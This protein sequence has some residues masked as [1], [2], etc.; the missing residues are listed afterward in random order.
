[1]RLSYFNL[2][3]ELIN[4]NSI[5]YNGLITKEDI[6]KH[7]TQED[8]FSYY[9]KDDASNLGVFHSP[10]RDDNIPS[11][12]LYFHR[13]ERNVIMFRDF[14][15]NDTGDFVVL[16]MKM[17]NVN[18]P[19]ALKK[20]AFDLGLS[21]L[22][23]DLQKAT[24]NYTRIVT[25]EKVE[26]GIKTKSNKSI[27]LSTLHI[28]NTDSG[29]N[30]E[31]FAGFTPSKI[32]VMD[33]VMKS[34]FLEAIEGLIPALVGSDGGIRAHVVLSGTAGTEELSADGIK[35]LSD[36]ETYGIL[37]MQWDIL[38]R[39]VNK[40]YNTWEEDK[41]RPFGTFI[42][43]QCRVDMPKIESTLADYLGKPHSEELKKIKIKDKPFL[44][45]YLIETKVSPDLK[46]TIKEIPVGKPVLDAP[47]IPES[48]TKIPY[49]EKSI[50]KAGPTKEELR[51][52]INEKALVK[53]AFGENVE[54]S[55]R[56]IDTEEG[57]LLQRYLKTRDVSSD[58]PQLT[59]DK[60][61][62]FGKS[63]LDK[64]EIPEFTTS[65][66][67]EAGRQL[68]TE[69]NVPIKDAETF[70]KSLG[71]ILDD[72]EKT[73][74]GDAGLFDSIRGEVSS[75]INKT[76][77]KLAELNPR[78]EI[79]KDLTDVLSFK[80]RDKKGNTMAL[81]SALERVKNGSL[82]GTVFKNELLE[83][84]IA[85]LEKVN[86]T[87]ASKMKKELTNVVEEFDL[88][89]DYEDKLKNSLQVTSMLSTGLGAFQGAANLGGL[90]AGKVLKRTDGKIPGSIAVNDPKLY[91]RM[92]PEYKKATS[93][94]TPDAF[95]RRIYSYNNEQLNQVADKLV[96]DPSLLHL[97]N[98]LKKAVV[99]NDRMGKNAAQFLIAQDP[100]TKK[101]LKEE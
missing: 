25:K 15:T 45:G 8:V 22:N 100:R 80:Y 12:A 10:L 16:V 33:E 83:P 30:R 43:G 64:P 24:V 76:S 50:T 39:G 54:G 36:P 60:E 2:M 23:V 92:Y 70:R 69:T 97:A 81:S 67:Y 37:P 99:E 90:M 28:I 6:L 96:A 17:F 101:L 61:I 85:E 89:K 20:I 86:P 91:S 73:K 42:P 75:S 65:T 77:D 68:V 18:Y 53:N 55:V 31:V 5:T 29:N 84:A 4:L 88:A 3:G 21:A 63:V 62:P 79:L 78:L 44:Q 71:T 32:V 48:I 94:E 13:D 19:E 87:L 27:L 9:L 35:A 58:M 41:Q 93:E 82:S 11:F 1:M 26:L 49:Q 40:E 14:A 34:I 7:V 74:F 95:S 46:R 52:D 66:P 56:E 47:E 59:P 72:A 51:K 98:K 57:K 38:E